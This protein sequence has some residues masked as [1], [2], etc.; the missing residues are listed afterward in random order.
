MDFRRW[1]IF[2]SCCW[3]FWIWNWSR[4]CR[5]VV[6]WNYIYFT[7]LP[8]DPKSIVDC[9]AFIRRI[10]NLLSWKTMTRN[11]NALIWHKIFSQVCNEKSTKNHQQVAFLSNQR[12]VD[13]VHGENVEHLHR[14]LHEF[15]FYSSWIFP[16]FLFIFNIEERNREQTLWIITS[17]ACCIFWNH[18]NNINWW[19]EIQRW[20]D[21]YTNSISVF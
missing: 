20:D 17:D 2:W 9:I 7:L 13:M 10:R 16:C 15:S 18:R 6:K 8:N 4:V 3:E 14:T 19:F 11:A 21:E 12:I 5:F 1:I